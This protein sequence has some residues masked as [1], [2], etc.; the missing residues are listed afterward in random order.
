MGTTHESHRRDDKENKLI[1][2]KQRAN[3]GKWCKGRVGIEHKYVFGERQAYYFRAIK[4]EC[5]YRDG[6]WERKTYPNAWWHCVESEYCEVCGRVK[7]DDL[8][9]DCTKYPG[10]VPTNMWD[11]RKKMKI[12][13]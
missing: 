3:R 7:R 10:G 1:R 13:K 8:G 6:W 11:W 5:G 12:D 4:K 9:K 2:G